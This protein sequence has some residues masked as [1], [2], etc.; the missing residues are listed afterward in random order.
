MA[1]V[2]WSND[3]SVGIEVIDNQHKR[4]LEYINLLNDAHEQKNRELVG[5][6]LDELVDY[7]QSH[8]SFEETAMEEAGYRFLAPHKKVHD[9]FVRRVGEY[10]QRFKLG[11]DVGDEL[12]H[13]LVTWLFNHIKRED[14]DYAKVLKAVFLK[15]EQAETASKGGWLGGALHRFFG[16]K[17]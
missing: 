4:I 8:F 16:G 14:A 10:V 15:Q 7:T 5:Q 6:V 2:S 11:E 1:Q 9:L 13:T 17:H 3:L 12:Q